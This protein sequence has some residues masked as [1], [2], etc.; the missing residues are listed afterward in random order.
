MTILKEEINQAILAI[1]DI[2]KWK[3]IVLAILS[4][5]GLGLLKDVEEFEYG[6]LLLFLAPY[7]CCYVDLIAH[8]RIANIYLIAKFLR[9]YA[10]S[11]NEA[12]MVRDYE[13]YVWHER[14]SAVWVSHEANARFLSSLVCGAG[15]PLIAFLVDSYR[16]VILEMKWILIVPA[17]GVLATVFLYSRLRRQLEGL[18]SQE[19]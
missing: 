16:K 15:I 12:L 8:E 6:Y 10:V 13:R 2:S 9:G 18:N 11:E 4:A 14:K 7:V 3:L 1:V 19:K 5:A 17:L